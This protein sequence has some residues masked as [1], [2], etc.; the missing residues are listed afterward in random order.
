MKK[1]FLI[2]SIIFSVAVNASADNHLLRELFESITG[3]TIP[4]DTVKS[5]G[6]QLVVSDSASVSQHLDSLLTASDSVALGDTSYRHILPDSVIA[7]LAIPDSVLKQL[8]GSDSLVLANIHLWYLDTT[9]Y[10]KLDSTLWHEFD[11]VHATLPDKSDI[12]KA[13]RK[14]RKDYRDSVIKNTPRILETFVVPDSMYYERMLVWSHDR[15]FNEFNLQ[16]IDTTYNYHFYDMPQVRNDVDAVYLGVSGSPMMSTNYFERPKSQEVSFAEAYLPY[17]YTSDNILLYNTKSPYTLLSYSG[18]PFIDRKKDENNLHLMSSQNIT[19]E[20]NL[21]LEFK[22]YGGGGMLDREK[23]DNRTFNIGT[24]YIGKNYALNAGFFGQSVNR[25]E[26]GG[27]NNDFW[28]QDTTVEYK[29]IEVNLA[30]ASSSMKRRTVF[31]THT[32][33]VPM[34]FFRKDAD[35]LSVGEGTVAYIGHSFEYSSFRRSYQDAITKDI[36]REFYFGQFNIND[37]Q[38]RDSVAVRRIDNRLYIKLQPYAP[39]AILSK[40]K[41]GVGYNY[42]MIY[43]FTPEY[44]ITGNKDKYDH[45]AYVY[46]GVSGMF[47]K[48]LEW[49]AFGRFDFSG[50]NIGD[51]QIA[52]D[53]R[54]SAYPIEE[55]IH[56]KGHV[57]TSLKKPDWFQQDL[58]FNHHQWNN[59]FG[60]VSETRLQATVDIP[61]WKLK[62]FANY[63]FVNNM[64]Y[65][66]SLSVVRQN[67]GQVHVLSAG[68]E[69]NIKVWAL[70]F[71]N[72]LLFQQSSDNNVLPL[73]TFAANLK[74]Y[75]QFPVVKNVMELQLGANGIFYTRYHVPAYSPDLNVFYNQKSKELGSVPYIDIFVNVQWKQACIYVKLTNIAKGWPSND[76]FSALH[77]VRPSRTLKIGIYWPFYVY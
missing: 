4:Q 2:A 74:Y 21:T 24:N 36:E 8:A 70:H 69:A 68:L 52:G 25:N 57:E 26:N 39:D 50:Y 42:R 43:N 37:A 72:R 56:F 27:M 63:A 75:I 6:N 66:D 11:S 77:Y 41:A 28:V 62:A 54:L 64:V 17:S 30:N 51:F 3:R 29:S 48:Y 16:K 71:D 67:P 35:S 49:N 18:N 12:R 38:S 58:F 55:G 65:Y 10:A 59:N 45:N 13:E 34:N 5:S 44:F 9:F 31:V 1:L 73:P 76:Y 7:A 60:K 46:G 23:T 20:L 22:R 19:P 14:N 33:A 47:R 61:K 32:L 53:I 40:I 15:Y